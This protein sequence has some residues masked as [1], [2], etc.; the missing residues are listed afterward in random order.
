V[1]SVRANT[2][3]SD[4]QYLGLLW[5][6]ASAQVD[7]GEAD[8]WVFGKKVRHHYLVVS[9]PYSNMFYTQVFRGQTA[10]C[11]CQGLKDIFSWIGN[12]PDVLIFDNATGVGRRVCDEVIET[13]L[14]SRF[15]LHYG[16]RVKWCNPRSG[17]E[18]GNVERAVSTARHNLFVPPSTV[19][20]DL[21]A[22]NSHLLRIGDERLDKT[23]YRKEELIGEL[24]DED[25]D[26][27]MS[28]PR[29]DFDVVRFETVSTDRYGYI[30]LDVKHTY[31]TSPKLGKSEVICGIR[32][33]SI[34][35]YDRSGTLIVTH[36]RQYGQR[37][38]ESIDP[39]SSMAL[40]AHRASAWPNSHLR[41]QMPENIVARL[42]TLDRGEL[43]KDLSL[44][45]ESCDRSGFDATMSA[46]EL[47]DISQPQAPDFF[48]V[49]CMAARIAGYGLDTPPEDGPDLSVYDQ[50][51]M[52]EVN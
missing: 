11:V 51:L 36:D 18:K 52:K 50:M 32:A 12:T 29:K 22:F 9:F 30:C 38:T 7:F 1:R 33:N 37:R 27:M 2:D 16:M 3:H 5:P 23:H 49:G 15:H 14:F 20:G 8:F 48:E 28:L 13:E 47:L 44:L 26:A 41:D 6:P 19:D 45:A 34:D 24:F 46:L 4:R 10:E 21:E 43:R 40:L 25:K 17:W 39:V 35:V 42:D 31:S